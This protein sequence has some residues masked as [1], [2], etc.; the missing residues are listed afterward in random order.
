MKAGLTYSVLDGPSIW[1][2]GNNICFST[3]YTG[4]ERG[5]Q[6]WVA[7]LCQPWALI[8][9]WEVN[10]TS[11]N[12]VNKVN[13][14]PPGLVLGKYLELAPTLCCLCPWG[15]HTCPLNPKSKKHLFIFFSCTAEHSI[16]SRHYSF[17]LHLSCVCASRLVHLEQCMGPCLSQKKDIENCLFRSCYFVTSLHQWLMTYLGSSDILIWFAGMC[18][19]MTRSECGQYR[20]KDVYLSSACEPLN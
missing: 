5:W 4:F 8:H 10:C 14:I 15:P 3:C 2:N 1:G 9:G 16:A 13:T 17:S 19:Q 11:V 6:P 18:T 12:T 20:C 7:D